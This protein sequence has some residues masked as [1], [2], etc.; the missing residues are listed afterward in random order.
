MV[1][2]LYIEE[3]CFLL[4]F[5][6]PTAFVKYIYCNPYINVCKYYPATLLG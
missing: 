2:S 6:N 3:F 4:V 5:K 1:A